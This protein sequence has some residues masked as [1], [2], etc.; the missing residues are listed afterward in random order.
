MMR[1]TV[2]TKR[3]KRCFMMTTQLILIV[4]SSYGSGSIA[5][6]LLEIKKVREMRREQRDFQTNMGIFS[7]F[8]DRQ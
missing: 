7:H 2:R 1:A 3:G 8:Q 4:E 5:R 6:A